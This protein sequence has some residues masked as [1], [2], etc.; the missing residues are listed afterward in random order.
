MADVVSPSV[1]SRMMSSIR[2]RDTKPELIVRKFLHRRGFRFRLFKRS[3]PGK[4]DLTL[5]RHGAVVFVH[6]CFWHGHRGCRYAI[7]P[8]TRSEFWK[9]KI[10]TNRVRDGRVMDELQRLGW[11]VAVIWEC[12]LRSDLE[13]SLRR[14]EAFL[15]S[16]EPQIEISGSDQEPRKE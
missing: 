12:A 10:D 16:N 3:L 15:S 5:T 1:R 14:L 4:P 9:G 7:V 13:C 2:G 6:G 11:R 8:S